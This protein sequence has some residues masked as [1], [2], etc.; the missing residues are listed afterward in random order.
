[1]N[2]TLKGSYGVLA[3]DALPFDDADL[4]TC[5]R[6]RADA[7][8]ADSFTPL[9]RTL[10]EKIPTALLPRC[11]QAV[12]ERCADAAVDPFSDRVARLATM[13]L[14][15]NR[16]SEIHDYLAAQTLSHARKSTLLA[17]AARRIGEGWV[18][19]NLNFVEVTIAVGRLQSAFL[20]LSQAAFGHFPARCESSAL[21]M[22]APGEEHVFGLM[23]VEELFRASGWCTTL[24]IADDVAGCRRWLSVRRH[25]IVCL[26]WSSDCHREGVA[27]LLDTLA[28]MDA[29]VIAGG[30]ASIRNRLWL[31]EMGVAQVCDDPVAGLD[32]SLRN[33]LKRRQSETSHAERSHGG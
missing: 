24:A 11:R 15:G 12:L 2:E 17:E 14:G 13:A 4:L 28:A 21:I 16:S 29:T 27:Q 20:R 10:V 5:Q 33:V 32:F 19:D 31:E 1:M 9:R 8:G 25:E 6:P 26:S 7:P 22:S 30:Q 3:H 18:C 23:L